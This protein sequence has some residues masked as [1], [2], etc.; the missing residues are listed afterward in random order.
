MKPACS[1]SSENIEVVSSGIVSTVKTFSS[2]RRMAPSRGPPSGAKKRHM[3]APA[4]VIDAAIAVGR[5][6][7]KLTN[8]G[9]PPK[10]PGHFLAGLSTVGRDYL[11]ITLLF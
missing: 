5:R 6:Y 11:R 4:K 7:G 10:T 3:M 9:F 1:V 8:M 2:G